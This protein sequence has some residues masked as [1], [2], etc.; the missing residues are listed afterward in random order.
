MVYVNE[1]RNNVEWTKARKLYYDNGIM[2]YANYW[3]TF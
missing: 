1:V 2:R 3:P